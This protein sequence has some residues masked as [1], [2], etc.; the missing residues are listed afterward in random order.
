MALNTILNK[1][2]LMVGWV[3]ILSISIA[4]MRTIF[5]LPINP[6]LSPRNPSIIV[7]TFLYWYFFIFILGLVVVYALRDK[8][9]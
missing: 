6:L 2:Q 5:A 4:I 8:G 3:M 9:K 1:K 7:R